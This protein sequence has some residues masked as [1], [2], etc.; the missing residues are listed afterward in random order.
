MDQLQEDWMA[1]RKQIE[2]NV[3][4]QTKDFTQCVIGRWNVLSEDGAMLSPG[5]D[6]FKEEL[7]KCTEEFSE[8]G[9][10]V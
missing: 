2:R 3:S 8:D 5:S 9:K 4:L 6:Y 10:N 1:S 7:E